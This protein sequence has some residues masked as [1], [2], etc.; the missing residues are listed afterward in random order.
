MLTKEEN[1]LITQTGP[2]TPCG[3]FMR[4]YWLPVALLEE[5]PEGGAPVPV[6]LLGEN[7]VLFR[8][9]QS[10]PGL[11]Y[12]FCSHRAW[13]LA[14]GYPE[15]EGLRCAAHGWL[16]N[17]EGRCLEMPLEPPENDFH[18]EIKHVAYPVE[19]RGGLVFAYLGPGEPPLIPSYEFLSVSGDQRRATKYFQECNYLQGSEATLDP[20]VVP[21]L[22]QILSAGSEAENGERREADVQVIPEETQ[23]GLR[24]RTAPKRGNTATS[25][26]RGFMMPSI[27][28]TPAAGMDGYL[29]HWHVPID[30]T[31]HWR[32]VIAVRSDG[33]ITD[34]DARRNG[35][36]APPHYRL[37]REEVVRVLRERADAESNFIAY[38]TALAES[39]GPIVDRTHE[40]LGEADAGIVLMRS[41]IYGGIEDVA[42]GM[43]PLLV[44]RSPRDAVDIKIHSSLGGVAATDSRSSR[45]HPGTSG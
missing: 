19:E 29:V 25:H 24:L 44:T 21:V 5:L 10:R 8:D 23:F 7:L 34:D 18:E 27:S 31:H 16:Y 20:L 15:E 32:F 13:D 6:R 42:E 9:G 36:E 37:D 1:D 30:D 40:S 41:L 26:A 38:T 17:R 28:V 35:A 33:P 3:D 14:A 22:R 12:R 2:G 39:Q 11:L 45:T 4:R 43:D